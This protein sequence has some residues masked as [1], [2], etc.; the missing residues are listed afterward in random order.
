MQSPET[1]WVSWGLEIAPQTGAPTC[2]MIPVVHGKLDVPQNENVLVLAL[3]TTICGADL[4][5]VS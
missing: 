3:V 4:G 1:S 2:C 5:M